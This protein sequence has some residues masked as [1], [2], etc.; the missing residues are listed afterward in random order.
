M[1]EEEKQYKK[2]IE[3]L[4]RM[5]KEEYGNDIEYPVRKKE[6]KNGNVSK[7]RNNS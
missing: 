6:E 1:T 5:V 3:E 7:Q 2:H 4:S